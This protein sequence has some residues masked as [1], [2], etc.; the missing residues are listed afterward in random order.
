MADDAVTETAAVDPAGSESSDPRNPASGSSPL[1]NLTKLLWIAA[2]LGL[3]ALAGST[4]AGA[5]AAIGIGALIFL[6]SF[7]SGCFFGFLFG[8]PRVL[9]RENEPAPSA[10]AASGAPRGLSSAE[11]AD[12]E[13]RP[14]GPSAQRVLSSN[15]NLERISDWLTTLIVGATL[16]ELHRINE[17]LLQFRQFLATSALV[18]PTS[19]GGR[20]AGVLPAIGPVILIFG[21]ACGF[22]FMYLNTRLV[23]VRM[24]QAV[25]ILISGEKLSSAAARTV[26]AFER[27]TTPG[28]SFVA[29]QLESK[30]RPTVEDALNL[31][32]DLLYKSEPDRIIELGG[33]LSNTAAVKRPDYWFYL[34]AAFGQKLHGADR[35]SDEWNSARDNALDCAR[36]AVALDAS[37]R[38]RLWTISNPSGPDDDLAPLRDDPE[39]RRIVGRPK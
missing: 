20:T 27:Q 11:A 39:F 15:T 31:M 28:F 34:A 9:S 37:Y 38:E 10:G 17:A 35:T 25:E 13:S 7:A 1:D 33:Q 32:F 8:V 22:L 12:T 36:R 26:L 29:Q 24:F 23:L 30:R 19:A 18:F 16:V 3:V 14:S 6:A 5:W 4:T 21:L 2:G